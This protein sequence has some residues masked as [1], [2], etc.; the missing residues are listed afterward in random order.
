MNVIK[1]RIVVKVIEEAFSQ[2]NDDK[3]VILK[4]ILKAC[5]D[6]Y[7]EDNYY[8][9]MSAIV[10][11]LLQADETFKEK[12]KVLDSNDVDKGVFVGIMKEVMS[13][14]VDDAVKGF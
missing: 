4:A 9:R 13:S 14:A 5:E 6:E 10:T 7:T 12:A 3:Y 1:K 8:A 2:G 11:W